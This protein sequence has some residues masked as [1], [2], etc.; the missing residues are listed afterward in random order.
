[1]LANLPD[2][3]R[4]PLRLFL[5]TFLGIFSLALTGWLGGVVEWAS[6]SAKPFPPL[7]TLGKALVAGAVAGA[8]AV[9]AFVV[10]ALEDK[11]NVPAVLKAPPSPGQNP[12]PEAGHVDLAVVLVAVAA[13]VVVLAVYTLI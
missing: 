10:N 2:Y 8:S 4:R 9:V 1:M 3:V 7:D 5:W 12:S 6:D 11:T 13:A